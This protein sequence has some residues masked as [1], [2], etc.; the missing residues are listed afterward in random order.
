ML[1]QMCDFIKYRYAQYRYNACDL[2]S[3]FLPLD[4]RCQHWSCSASVNVLTDANLVE[5]REQLFKESFMSN[6]LIRSS[7][8]VM[9]AS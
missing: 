9:N 5:H 3:N 8:L 2:L 7:V 4:H 6:N 1:V